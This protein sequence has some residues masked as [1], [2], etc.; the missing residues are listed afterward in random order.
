MHYRKQ[1]DK[2]SWLFFE[3][4]EPRGRRHLAL[5]RFDEDG[6]PIIECLEATDEECK[7]IQVRAQTIKRPLKS[8]RQM[9][10]AS[11]AL[12]DPA[13]APEE[14]LPTVPAKVPPV[15]EAADRST[16]DETR[17]DDAQKDDD[18]EV[19]EPELSEAMPDG[20]PTD[21]WFLRGM[22]DIEESVE[23]SASEPT[24]SETTS[25]QQVVTALVGVPTDRITI[26]C[27]G[28]TEAQYFREMI[29]YLGLE[30]KVM[31]DVSSDKNPYGALLSLAEV[32]KPMDEVWLVFDR[33]HH[34]GY[35][36]ALE[37]AKTIPQIHCVPTNPS[38]EYW[39]LLHFKAFKDDLP[40]DDQQERHQEV[41][42]RYTGHGEVQ[43][44][45]TTTYEYF[46]RPE[47]CLAKLK[48]LYPGYHKNS[49]NYFSRLAAMM[50]LA[51]Q[52]AKAKST[53]QLTHW[54]GMPDLIDRLCE[55]AEL[56]PKDFFDK[57]QADYPWSAAQWLPDLSRWMQVLRPDLCERLAKPGKLEKL[58]M[59]VQDIVTWHFNTP[60]QKSP[61]SE[62]DIQVLDLFVY[63]LL[64]HID[65]SK[66]LAG[67]SS[68]ERKRLTP[69]SFAASLNSQ[70]E[71]ILKASELAI[72]PVVYVR[73]LLAMIHLLP[74]LKDRSTTEP[75][76]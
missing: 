61:V 37:T 48:L 27:E 25:P 68:W 41:E 76:L 50:P 52:R 44:I 56:T 75:S 1:P 62:E 64:G 8:K 15:K 53:D 34:E 7:A 24:S 36:R 32:V 9:S 14:A 54:S 31:I 39:F 35:Y 6:E 30:G 42:T 19:V 3:K 43:H 33:D 59:R 21:A 17:K 60:G 67:V 11:A 73:M 65:M 72:D 57:L 51:Y 66:Q 71:K 5:V 45:T 38:F 74:L 55:L 12:K 18:G 70:I 49:A 58:L 47:T 22:S 26:V 16:D 2:A 10:N 69:Q 4:L 29:E 13:C 23:P 63:W 40:F 28:H 20:I 46:T